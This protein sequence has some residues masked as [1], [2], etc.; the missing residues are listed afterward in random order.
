MMMMKKM[1]KEEEEK[2][3]WDPVQLHSFSTKSLILFDAPDNSHRWNDDGSVSKA[4]PQ[5]L[6]ASVYERQRSWLTNWVLC[7]WSCTRP[8]IV[9]PVVIGASAEHPE[10]RSHHRHHNHHHYYHTVNWILDLESAE[11][12]SSAERA[13]WQSQK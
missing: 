8:G 9:A 3:G 1:E 13:E 7:K 4:Y 12:N 5:K 10:P 2:S 11:S 6:T